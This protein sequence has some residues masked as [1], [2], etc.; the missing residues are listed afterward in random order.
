MSPKMFISYSWSNPAHEQWVLN[1]ATE[2]REAGVDVILDKWDLRE[3]HDA[4][5]F[6]ETM[7]S[8]PSVKKVLLICDKTYADKANSRKGGVGTETQII[9]AEMYSKQKQ[10]KFAALVKETDEDGNPYLP[11][12]YK[13]RIYINFSEESQYPDSFE[14]LVRWAFDQ[15]LYTKPDIGKPPAY[16][17]NQDN[18]KVLLT[19]SRYKRAVDAIRNGKEYDHPATAEYFSILSEELKKL[20]INSNDLLPSEFGNAVIKSI[21]LFT[22]YR[23]EITSLVNTIASYRPSEKMTEIIHSFLEAIAPLQFRP[24]DVNSW[25]E[26]DFDNFRFISWE[27]FIYIVS[28]FIKHGHFSLAN[29]FLRTGYYS[30]E[31]YEYTRGPIK[32]Y[33]I[34]DN[35]IKS[36]SVI[37]T[38]DGQ[39]YF[40]PRA[41]LLKDRSVGSGLE[42]RHL[43]QTDFILWFRDDFFDDEHWRWFPDTHV[44]HRGEAVPYEIFAR[45]RSKKYFNDV[46]PLLAAESITQVKERIFEIN[47]Q[48]QIPRWQLN[49]FSP[50]KILGIDQIATLP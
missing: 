6:M 45:S 22:P 40:S 28:I 23:D 34:F 9:S 14:K 27:I 49:T 25:K 20:R 11:I 38:A 15:P 17:K 41:K 26:T 48:K 35:E 31:N 24:R 44:Y 16:L 37:C 1:L 50:E 18:S 10:D 39:N 2:L 29:H 13:S 3:G 43:M 47:S 32:S 46:L 30:A 21:N 19:S 7:V 33:R 8:D 12:Y 36:L 5:A 42:F 4:Y